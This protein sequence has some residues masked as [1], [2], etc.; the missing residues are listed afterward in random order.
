[1][2]W[3]NCMGQYNM[4]DY[5]G[6]YDR[7]SSKT[8]AVIRKL[9]N[10]FCGTYQKLCISKLVDTKFVEVDEQ[11]MRCVVQRIARYRQEGGSSSPQPQQWPNLG[12]LLHKM[13]HEYPD[14]NFDHQSIIK[15]HIITEVWLSRYIPT[16]TA[17]DRES[18]DALV[19]VCRMISRYM[20]YLLANRPEMLPIY[21]G[22]QSSLRSV[23]WLCEDLQG[24]DVNDILHR[25]ILLST[26]DDIPETPEECRKEQLLEIEEL[27]VGLLLHAASKSRPEMHAALLARGGEL[28]TFIW[29]LMAH[30][31]LGDVVNCPIEMTANATI[32]QR[33]YAF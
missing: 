7:Q 16:G 6:Q 9:A 29:L 2:L 24:A 20:V 12:P 26:K 1:M 19:R 11:I 4:L 21:D 32:G 18:S 23:A 17:V 27:W 10:V 25:T 31:R 22:G 13:V 5:L 30:Y 28:L 3:S 33:H 8:M 15:F 14:S